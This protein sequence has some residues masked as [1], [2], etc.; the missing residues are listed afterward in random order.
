MPAPLSPLPIDDALPELTAALRAGSAAVLVAPPGAG[1]TT[2][3]PLALLGEPWVAGRKI[4]VL[5]PRR[6]AARAAATRMAQTLGEEAGQ[7]VGYRARF[8]SKVGRNTRIEVIT[9]GIFTRMMLDDPELSDVAAVLFDEFHERSLDA[10]LGLALALDAQGA[11]RE[12]LRLLVMSATLDGA[13]V[14][15]LLSGAPVVESLGRAFPV[16]TRYAGRVPGAPVERQM[17]EVIARALGSESGSILAFLPGAAEIRRTERF[18]REAVRDPAIDIA[19][20]YGALPPAEQDRAISPAPPGR[21]KVVLAT[22]IAETSLTIEG[23]RLVVD[24][25]LARVPRFEPGVGLTRLETVRVSRA[26]AD[27]RRGRAGRTEPGICL[28]LWHEPE[29][30]SLP[31]FATPEILAADLSRLVLDLAVWGARDPATLAFLDPPPAPAVSEAKA[32]LVALGALEPDGQVSPLGRAMARLPLEPRLARMVIEGARRGVGEEAAR[33]AALVSERGLGGDAPDLV[34]RLMDLSRDRSRRADEARR[35][36]ERWAGEAARQVSGT[37]APGGD[38]PSPAVLLALAFPD[39]VARGR[40][41]GR[42]FVLANGRGAALDPAAA[43]ARARFLAIAELAGTADEA[44]ILLAAE[45]TEA[46]I[47]AEFGTE[48]TEGMET[49]F[50]VAASALRA[51]HVRRLGALVL[52]E[53]TAPVKPG[54]ETARALARAAASRGL[55]RLNWSDAQR[56]WFDRARFLHASAP[57]LWPDLSW[58]ALAE[59]VE[60]WLAPALDDITTLG[61]LTADRLGR[62]L[63]TLLPGELARRMET[64]APTHMEVPTG[65]RLP[66]DYAAEGG[67]ALHVRVQELFGLTTHPAIAGGR[68]PLVL[69]LLSP[70]HRPIQLTRDLPAFWAGSWRDVRADM[71]GRYP[72][73][74]WPEDPAQAE[75][76]RRAKPRS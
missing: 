4:L 26:A 18:L 20:L 47:E 54:A 39:R 65:S 38:A 27:Q 23:V 43:L 45:L 33:I 59:T 13:R 31:A 37:Q 16:E 32:L 8:G 73:H 58:D 50:D 71:R 61:A 41:D 56:Q 30:A 2:R 19:P 66:I 9:E 48:I 5:E 46:E 22:S 1:K 63:S 11:L 72:R 75:P 67:P 6:L 51:R 74:P 40:G 21:R 62:A 25:G 3:V 44:R 29:T 14:A 52:A 49:A 53:R 12:D 15:R 64:E 7:T 35:L 70:A 55:D 10:D 76:T 17:A 36:A 60:D 42:R 69:S 68:V 28:R 24:S 57:E 34:H